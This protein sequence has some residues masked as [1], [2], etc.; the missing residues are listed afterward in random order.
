MLNK[1]KMAKKLVELRGIKSRER[2]AADLNISYASLVSY[3]LGERVPRDELKIK[4][5]KYYNTPIEKIFF[6]T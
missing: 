6:L 3:E 2:V 4:I 1:E 5:S